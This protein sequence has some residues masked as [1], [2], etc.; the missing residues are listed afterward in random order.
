MKPD[1]L[2]RDMGNHFQERLLTL[3]RDT[4]DTCEDG[5]MSGGDIMALLISIL[6]SETLKGCVALKM[7]EDEYVEVSRQGHR[8]MMRKQMK[9]R[10]E[11]H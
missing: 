8:K 2:T 10:R 6:M 7:T 9:E 3:M 1:R 5:G 11:K 4:A